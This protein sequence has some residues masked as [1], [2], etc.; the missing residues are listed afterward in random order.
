MDGKNW[1]YHGIGS[2][3][4][5]N[6]NFNK[7]LDMWGDQP[8]VSLDDEGRVTGLSIE[9]FGAKGKVPDAIGQLTELRV[10]ALVRIAKLQ[11]ADCLPTKIC[12]NHRN[13][14]YA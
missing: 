8:G 11:V 10:L 12:K 1:G 9:G 2:P 4:G 6:W 13:K 7:E 5:T 14:K 3:E